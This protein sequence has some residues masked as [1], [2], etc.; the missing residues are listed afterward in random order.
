MKRTFLE[1]SFVCSEADGGCNHPFQHPTTTIVNNPLLMLENSKKLKHNLQKDEFENSL[2]LGASFQNSNTSPSCI[3]SSSS[4]DVEK[5]KQFELLTIIGSQ[6][7]NHGEFNN[8]FDIVIDHFSQL[9]FISDHDNKRVKI[10]N[11]HNLTLKQVIDICDKP[12]Y[13]AI[14]TN[15]TLLITS[16]EYVYKYS[17]DGKQLWKL[18]SPFQA[19]T[20][21]CVDFEGRIYVCDCF[22]HRI[23]VLSQNGQVEYTISS[24]GSN[25]GQLLYPR[26]IDLDHLNNLV[27]CDNGNNRRT[28][29]APVP[30][31]ASA[32]EELP[33]TK[34]RSTNINDDQK[35]LFHWKEVKSSFNINQ[36]KTNLDEIINEKA[37][38][39]E[40]V[41]NGELP[42]PKQVLQ[43]PLL[44][45]ELLNIVLPHIPINNQE[46][47]IL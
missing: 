41:K 30:T 9:L 16:R 40:K 19:P 34:F 39:T 31:N 5:K 8:P 2:L 32:K 44:M 20:G 36:G 3:L 21:I 11:L 42:K 13:M 24:E 45:Y 15:N 23:V 10:F 46:K 26:G 47:N 38:I 28:N 43:Y 35:Q 29:G 22:S 12:N 1:H 27:V 14:H 37:S 17:Y 18:S 6:G 7:N 4:N 33:P 25:P